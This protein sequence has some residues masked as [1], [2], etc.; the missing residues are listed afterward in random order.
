MK[1]NQA[2]SGSRTAQTG[3]G[4][5][6]AQSISGATQTSAGAGTGRAGVGASYESAGADTTSDIGQAE[7]YIVN[8]KRLIENALS[9]DAAL[10]QVINTSAQRLAR[11]AEDHDQALRQVALA[12]V[13]SAVTLQSRMANNAVTHD[14]ALHGVNHGER[15]RSMRQGDITETIREA[16]ISDNPVMQDSVI[17]ALA[18][19]VAE[20]ISKVGTSKA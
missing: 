20:R 15:E 7:G 1:G 10:R 6:A 19:K 16:Q 9:D 2:A 12:A 3:S 4:A 13:T 18:A 11:N 17:A 14:E 5:G 8:L